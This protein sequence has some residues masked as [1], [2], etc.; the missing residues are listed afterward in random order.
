MTVFP[1]VSDPRQVSEFGSDTGTNH[2][3]D[4]LLCVFIGPD[5][6]RTNSTILGCR[7]GSLYIGTTDRKVYMKGS[8]S[9]TE[10]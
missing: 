9:F 2:L 10:I 8:S 3:Y 4:G 7:E 6:Q 5:S 1:I